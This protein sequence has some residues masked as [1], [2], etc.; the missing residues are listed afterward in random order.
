MTSIDKKDFI[1]RSIESDLSSAK[2]VLEKFAA[3]IAVQPL[4]AFS[5]GDKAVTAAAKVQVLGDVLAVLKSGVD[6]EKVRKHAT[7]QALQAAKWPARST[8]VMS[9]LA[10][11]E[12]GA[13]WASL[14]ERLDF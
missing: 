6:V 12:K 11:Q 5:W 4:Y 8:S 10:E 14:I 2:K 1:I 3:D 7:E 13:V 9:N